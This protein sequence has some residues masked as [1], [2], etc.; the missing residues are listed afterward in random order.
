MSTALKEAE[1]PKSVFKKMPRHRILNPAY[2]GNLGGGYM[3]RL[4][5]RSY[6]EAV[7]ITKN[8]NGR[9]GSNDGILQIDIHGYGVA[10]QEWASFEHLKDKMKDGLWRNLNGAPLFINGVPSGKVGA[11]EEAKKKK[12]PEPEPVRAPKP[13]LNDPKQFFKAKIATGELG[14][15]DVNEV[16]AHL[17]KEF[18]DAY[19][20]KRYARWENQYAAADMDWRPD[21][22]TDSPEQPWSEV[23]WYFD[24]ETDEGKL[25]V[26]AMQGDRDG[27]HDSLDSAE[28]GTPEG[29]ELEE[30]YGSPGY[31]QAVKHYW[32]WVVET[33]RDP[34]GY[35]KLPSREVEKKWIAGFIK[36]GERLKLVGVRRLAAEPPSPPMVT[37]EQAVAKAAEDPEWK[38]AVEYL[39]L[40]PQ[41]YTEATEQ[42]VLGEGGKWDSQNRLVLKF[43]FTDKEIEGD[44]VEFIRRVA[45]EALEQLP[46]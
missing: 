19:R 8:R 7:Y 32:E 15:T 37:A 9:F 10:R 45:S 13:D 24:Y 16:L 33:G 38:K 18:V 26:I 43:S 2:G 27:N 23:L 35:V 6:A 30:Y 34:L 21:F 41:G 4:L 5:G 17:P 36:E 11:V 40:D 22:D 20:N 29:K 12:K 3:R 46:Q 28:V 31:F 1:D 14:R 25:F 42:E 39:L 44:Q